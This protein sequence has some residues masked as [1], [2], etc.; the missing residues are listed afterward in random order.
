[1]AGGQIIETW[2][3]RETSSSGEDSTITYKYLI[4]KEPSDVDA[5]ILLAATAP[6]TY[7]GLVPRGMSLEPLENDMWIGKVD[8]RLIDASPARQNEDTWPG[9][10]QG[11]TGGNTQHVNHSLETIQA[12]AAA[13]YTA[14]TTDHKQAIGVDG[15]G[16]VGG[17]DIVM[18][19]FRFTISRL[20]SD[21]A[22]TAAYVTGVYGLTGCVNNNGYQPHAKLPTF[23]AGELLLEDFRFNQKGEDSWEVQLN[24]AASPNVTDLTVGDISEID[25]KG[26]EYLWFQFEKSQQNNKG[27][28]RPVR[29]YVERVYPTG[30]FS[31]L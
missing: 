25:K 23:A 5:E 4:Y 27:A 10:L 3:S 11:G 22:F 6:D 14:A 1:M 8:Y 24:F 2:D 16:N 19:A 17:T 29:A 31:G 21:D 30:N 9:S 13:G 7:R 12:K 20:F 28:A 15:E 26:W 18:R